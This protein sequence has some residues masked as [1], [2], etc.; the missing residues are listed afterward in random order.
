MAEAPATAGRL[1]PGNTWRAIGNDCSHRQLDRSGAS[2]SDRSAV[3]F[4]IT[5]WLPGDA[6]VE[7]YQALLRP[8]AG[9]QFGLDKPPYVRY[10]NWLLGMLSGNLGQSFTASMPV[11]ELIAT[12]LVVDPPP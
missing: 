11:T 12:R 1:A 10:F 5:G 2:R 6:A 4:I 3:I 7:R 8:R 9:A